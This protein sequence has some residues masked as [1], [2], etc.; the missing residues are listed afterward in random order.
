MA[1][2]AEITEVFAIEDYLA[3]FNVAVRRDV[4]KNAIRA[5][6]KVVRDGAKRRVPVKS[7]RLRTRLSYVVRDYQNAIVGVVGERVETGERAYG[8][9]VEHGHQM[10]N[11][12]GGYETV[13]AKPF[14]RPAVDETELEQ[15]QA[16]I[17]SVSTDMKRNGL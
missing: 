12:S 16:A 13:G 14:L 1:A 5:V 2:S 15:E 17:V 3:Q 10:Q 11:F 8:H 7:G 4:V 6:C 9:L